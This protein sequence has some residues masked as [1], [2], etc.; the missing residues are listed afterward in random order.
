VRLQGWYR[1]PFGNHD[2]RWF[3]G[4]RPTNLVRDQG[5]ESYDAA[6]RGW[7]PPDPRGRPAGEQRPAAADREWRWWAVCLPGLLAL[8]V[9]GL[10]LLY[11]AA[12]SSLGCLDGCPPLGE[13][14]PVGTAGEAVLAVAGVA[15]LVA[16]LTRPEWRRPAASALWV[17]FAL[18]CGG[19]LLIAMA[20]APTPSAL[21]PASSEVQPS[22]PAVASATPPA[23]QAPTPPVDVEG[24]T[25]IG[26][27]V[28][29]VSDESLQDSYL[30]YLCYDVPFVSADGARY[31]GSV[32]F[33]PGGWM[34]G[35]VDTRGPGAT[36]AECESG[37]YVGP[38]GPIKARP[39]RWDAQLSL[40]TSPAPS[41]P[42][43]PWPTPSPSQ[44][45]TG[46]Y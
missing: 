6:P 32:R 10:S 20:V 13:G 14:R 7:L 2:E 42:T 12:A 19:A 29:Q 4:G 1:D 34:T 24:C 25:L 35:P 40:C 27:E 15:L 31:F 28:L 44:P 45:G 36:R 26:G 3:S 41:V 38:S 9:A 18:A 17:A 30:S 46:G 23:P 16:G 43:S 21:L 11:S 33:G 39:G 37:R 5:T 22:V 8:A